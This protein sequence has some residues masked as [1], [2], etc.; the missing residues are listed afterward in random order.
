[1]IEES[2]NLCRFLLTNFAANPTLA[3]GGRKGFHGLL[4][5]SFDRLKKKARNL[6]KK[7]KTAASADGG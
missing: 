6:K 3:K 4:C 2:R 1:V 7:E 5:R